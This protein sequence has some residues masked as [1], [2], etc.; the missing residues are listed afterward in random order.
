MSDSWPPQGQR[1]IFDYLRRWT[2]EFPDRV[3][4]RERNGEEYRDWTWA[5]AASEVAAI[6][7][8]LEGA[9]GD[10]GARVA[11]MSRNCAHWVLADLAIIAAG[12]VTV[13]IFT[14]LPA[15]GVRYILDFS[16]AGVLFVGESENWAAV[17]EVVP[18]HVKVVALP[19]V[20]PGM[21]HERWDDL[22]AAHVGS[23]PR[24][25]C[26]HDELLSVVFTSGTT[27]VPKGVMQTHDS[28]LVPMERAGTVFGLRPHPRFLSYL[29]MAHIAER[30]LVAIQS[31]IQC[32]SI[33]FNEGLPFL[34]RDMADTRPS[35]FF[36]A[37]RV[38][39]QLQQGMLAKF[40]SQ[41]ALDAALARDG[42]AVRE[43]VSQSLG[44][45][46]ADYLLT[47]AAPTPPSLIEWYDR[48]GIQLMEGFG[49]TEAMALIVNVPGQRRIGSIGR[50]G[51]GVEA[52]IDPENNELMCRAAGLAVGYYKMPEQTAETFVDG[53]VRTG[54]TARVDEDGYYY[55]TGRVKEYFKTIQGKFVSPAPIES[56]FARS[57]L[58]EQQCLLGRGFS[59]TVMVCVLSA[60]GQRQPREELEQELRRLTEEVNGRVEKHARIGAL[61]VTREPW[62]IESGMLTPTLKLRRHEVDSRFGARAEALARSGAERGEILL[63]WDAS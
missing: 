9:I 56:E 28:M 42:D 54:D 38:W 6:A 40:G 11:V 29:P 14:T 36:G 18:G 12:N 47:A 21:A 7:A 60:L 55:I 59:R 43:K 46:E 8:W 52:R 49:Q 63:E 51:D 48:L 31:L 15:E 10:S 61:I 27:A 58:V 53:W 17:R 4:L 45:Q 30:Q 1:T 16:E 20:E 33:T 24:H 37:P 41:E 26:R 62:T 35:F 39:E 19:G 32:G 5:T 44:L 2:H 50:K 22:L 34:V 23:Q 13:P 3:W 25:V 57:L